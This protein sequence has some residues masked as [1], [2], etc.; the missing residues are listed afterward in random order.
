MRRR[1]GGALNVGEDVDKKVKTRGEGKERRGRLVLAKGG[2]K[3]VF[4]RA[5]II[6]PNI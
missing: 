5:S 4:L 6:V 3:A 1:E 2:V